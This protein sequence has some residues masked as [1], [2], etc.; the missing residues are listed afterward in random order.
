VNDLLFEQCDEPFG[1]ECAY[2]IMENMDISTYFIERCMNHTHG[3]QEDHENMYLERMLEDGKVLPSGDLPILQIGEGFYE[4]QH[5]TK[6]IFRAVC[7]SY[8]GLKRPSVCG[9]CGSCSD[10]RYCLWFLECKD[11]GFPT[12]EEF[13]SSKVDELNGG[14]LPPTNYW[15]TLNTPPPDHV[16]HHPEPTRPEQ[17]EAATSGNDG[18]GNNVA[19][20]FAIKGLLIG[21]V[22]SGAITVFFVYWDYRARQELKDFA[23]T[24][25]LGVGNASFHGNVETKP[26]GSGNSSMS[27][28]DLEGMSN[29]FLA[30]ELPDIS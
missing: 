24:E 19:A 13:A 3:V 29:E 10:V 22:C 2:S 5:D 27:A 20:I 21:L 18:N 16:D 1:Q 25:D 9:Y 11:T 8:A 12:F 26:R 14:S 7:A 4:G 23:K 15:D 30:E 17:D 28:K 6:A